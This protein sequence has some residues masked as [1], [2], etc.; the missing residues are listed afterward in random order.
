MKRV[1]KSIRIFI[2]ELNLRGNKKLAKEKSLVDLH[3]KLDCDLSKMLPTANIKLYLDVGRI[4]GSEIDTMF[5]PESDMFFITS[6]DT[7]FDIAQ[8]NCAILELSKKYPFL[9]FGIY[10]KIYS[11]EN[12]MDVEPDPEYDDILEDLSFAL[13]INGEVAKTSTDVEYN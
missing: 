1:A 7:A 10:V 12:K 5:I 3:D 2:S 9:A 6:K 8:F 11:D 4:F 13:V